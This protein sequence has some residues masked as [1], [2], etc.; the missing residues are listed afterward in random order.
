MLVPPIFGISECRYIRV[1][2]WGFNPLS[3]KRVQFARAAASAH[4][5]TFES[6]GPTSARNPIENAHGLH[7]NRHV[8]L[9]NACA[10]SEN[11]RGLCENAFGLHE[12]VR[13]L[14]ENVLYVGYMKIYCTVIRSY[15]AGVGG[16]SAETESPSPIRA[17]WPN[18][19]QAKLR[20]Q[21]LSCFSLHCA[22]DRK[23]R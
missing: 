21:F 9:E 15:P 7:E 12:N 19:M 1:R 18:N 8:V 23:S 2:G 3:P 14:H 10:L 5:R 20:T 11:V 4:P 22:C 13:G 17:P 16:I 6:F